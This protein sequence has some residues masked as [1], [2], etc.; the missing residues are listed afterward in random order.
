MTDYPALLKALAHA[1]VKFVVV[2][3]LAA[4]A[5]GSARVTSDLDVVYAR[6]PANLKNLVKA[7]KPLHPKLRGAPSGVPFTFDERSLKSG[8]NFTFAT[9]LGDI[10]ILGEITG[11][12]SYEDIVPHTILIELF[13]VS[14][15]CLDLDKLIEVKRAAGRQ[16]DL[17]AVAELELIRDQLGGK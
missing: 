1:G 17:E 9:E 4:T 6:D 8:L 16:K 5:H 11:G 3:G 12:G 2:G 15:R 7:L 10:D 14:C 13:D